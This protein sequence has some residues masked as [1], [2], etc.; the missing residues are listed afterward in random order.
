[1]ATVDSVDMT[2][3]TVLAYSINSKFEKKIMR[4]KNFNFECK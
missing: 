1:M 4:F 3:F 2:N